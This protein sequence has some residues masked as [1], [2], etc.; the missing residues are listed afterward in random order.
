MDTRALADTI[1]LDAG[2]DSVRLGAFWQDRPAVVV[3]LRHFGCLYCR[4]HAVQMSGALPEIEA[5]GGALVFVGNGSPR[6]ATWFKRKFVPG[7]TVLTDPELR[8]Y[9]IIGARSGMLSTLGPRTWSSAI[10]A[11]RRGARQSSV[12]GHPFQQG[13]VLVLAPDDE[14]VYSYLSQRAGDHPPDVEVLGAMRRAA[15]AAMGQTA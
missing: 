9:R 4:E 1:I 3:W 5:M 14:L 8:S 6:A 11:V 7:A 2:G 10:R 15:R 12:R 13:A